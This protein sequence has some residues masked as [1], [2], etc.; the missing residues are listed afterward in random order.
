MRRTRTS[1]LDLNRTRD[2]VQCP[3]PITSIEKLQMTGQV[4]SVQPSFKGRQRGGS[5]H[6]IWQGIPNIGDP[7]GKEVQDRSEAALL[8]T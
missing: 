3:N 8:G 2:L 1:L 4:N 5:Y 6:V 7:V